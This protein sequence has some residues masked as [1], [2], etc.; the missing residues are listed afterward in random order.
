MTYL[1]STTCR[2][3]EADKPGEN[4]FLRFHESVIG[5]PLCGTPVR[6]WHGR[7]MKLIETG[8]REVDCGRCIRIRKE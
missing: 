1:S 3:V 2:I 6:P 4:S 5:S 8:E 7:P